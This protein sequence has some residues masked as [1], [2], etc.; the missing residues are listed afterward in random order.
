MNDKYTKQLRILKNCTI[1]GLSKRVMHSFL[2]C[3]QYSPY[4]AKAVSLPSRSRIYSY[5][6]KAMSL[7]QNLCNQILIKPETQISYSSKSLRDA[8]LKIYG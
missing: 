5:G 8:E 1:F 7:P 4:S 3:L 6:A 2:V